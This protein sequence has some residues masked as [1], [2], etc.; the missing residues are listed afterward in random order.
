MI[1]SE[2]LVTLDE[3]LDNVFLLLIP[4]DVIKDCFVSLDR[5]QV[6]D[7]EVLCCCVSQSLNGNGGNL[8]C[9]YPS[10]GSIT[11]NHRP[12]DT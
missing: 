2:L 5:V 7:L 11:N 10:S 6:V 1:G 8:V 12:K 4:H 3:S 9:T